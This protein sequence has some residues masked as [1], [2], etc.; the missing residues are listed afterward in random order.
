MLKNTLDYIIHL[1]YASPLPF[2][3]VNPLC[4]STKPYSTHFSNSSNVQFLLFYAFVS[5]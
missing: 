1:H 3:D 4:I 2:K 5:L